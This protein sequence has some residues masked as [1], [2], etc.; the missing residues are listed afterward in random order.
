MYEC[1]DCGGRMTSVALTSMP[2]IHQAHCQECNAVY[3]QDR[4]PLLEPLPATFRKRQEDGDG[5]R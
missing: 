2:P 3:Q 5:G 4:K 1:P